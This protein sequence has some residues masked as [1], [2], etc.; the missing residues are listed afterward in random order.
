MLALIILCGLVYYF[1]F[2][3]GLQTGK[4]RIE[5]LQREI[6]GLTA[7]NESLKT[8]LNLRSQEIKALREE[9]LKNLPTPPPAPQISNED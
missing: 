9:L 6:S 2:D 3:N 8:Q 4:M 7:E 5:R 1:S